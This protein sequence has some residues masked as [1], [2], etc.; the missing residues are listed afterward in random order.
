MSDVAIGLGPVLPLRPVHLDAALL[1][2]GDI[3]LSWVRRSRADADS[4]AGDDAPLD[5]A[6]EAYRLTIFNGGT[7]VRTADLS[8]AAMTYS[9]A[10]QTADFGA[11]PSSFDFTVA[12]LST[13]YG[14][15]LAAAATFTS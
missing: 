10:D 4:W 11:P 2:I 1:D 5:F 3:A 13:L 12:Q 15:G 9:V 7:Q 8:T 14:P 6:P